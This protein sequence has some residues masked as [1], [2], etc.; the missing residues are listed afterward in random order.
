MI[1]EEEEDLTETVFSHEAETQRPR[2]CEL[3]KSSRGG[4]KL[5]VEGFHFNLSRKVDEK[6]Y[7]SCDLRL[8]FFY[9]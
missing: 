7:W 3:F 6:F 5:N 1:S 4:N 8:I 2:V 9:F